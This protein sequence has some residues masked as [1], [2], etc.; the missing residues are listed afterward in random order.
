MVPDGGRRNAASGRR[1]LYSVTMRLTLAVAALLALP[2]PALAQVDVGQAGYYEA[3]YGEPVDVSLSDLLQNGGSYDGRAVRTSGRLDL[4]SASVQRQFVIKDVFGAALAVVPVGE[5][6]GAWNSDA[7][8][9]LGRAVDFT[10]VFYERRVVTGL[11]ED[12]RGTLNFWSFLG[13]PEDVKVDPSKLDSTPLERLLAKPQSFEGRTVKVVGQFRGRN[14]YGDLPASTQKSGADWVIKDDLYAVWVTG[15]K[16]KGDGF[17]LDS[18]LKRDTGKWLQVVGRVELRGKGIY[19]RAGSVTLTKP[20]SPTAEAKPVPP[21]PPRPKLPPVVVF[22][23]PLDGETE[24]PRSGPFV[25]QFSKDMNEESFAG[26][27][28]LR[29]AGPRQPGDRE[30]LPRLRYDLGRRALYV[31]PADL[32]RPGRVVEL[33]LLPGIADTDGLTLQARPNGR[34]AEGAVDVLRYRA[35]AS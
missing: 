5:A 4:S 19:L 2:F 21:P 26:N 34:K 27:V 15:R 20:P 8:R 25:V 23:L 11:G 33:L 22:A 7:T 28:V 13:P 16:P 3:R 12:I 1:V 10:G 31:D 32:L 14:L 29:Y 30:I 17:E 9:L 24:V 35:S 18:S 6:E